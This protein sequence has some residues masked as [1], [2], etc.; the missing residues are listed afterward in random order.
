[1]VFSTLT[2]MGMQTVKIPKSASDS[3][4][5]S[6]ILIS[7]NIRASK[8]VV[9][10]CGDETE[11][12]GIFSYLDTFEKS[13]HFGTVLGFVMNFT[14]GC[15]RDDTA[16]IILNPAQ[17][18]WNPHTEL[19]ESLE[20][21]RLRVS[22]SM[23]TPVRDPARRNVIPGNNTAYEHTQYVFDHVILPCVKPTTSL[24]IVGVAAGGL[25]VYQFLKRNCK[26]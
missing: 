12:L 10:L 19:A 16:L 4:P 25:A 26:F 17:C 24:N 8:H 1:V 2:N 11:D 15:L 21:F 14:Q 22:T 5:H 9:V 7:P 23:I 20:T 3:E 18:Y 6:R 13:I